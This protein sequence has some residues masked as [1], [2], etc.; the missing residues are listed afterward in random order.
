M[1]K[2]QLRWEWPD[3]T[4]CSTS[5]TSQ[6]EPLNL[7][8]VLGLWQCSLLVTLSGPRELNHA[9]IVLKVFVTVLP[10]EGL[11]GTSPTK[12]SFGTSSAKHS[13]YKI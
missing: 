5:K 8:N 1:Y 4:I 2:E 10:K 9:K 13:V 11:V 6:S 12:T 3:S 7:P